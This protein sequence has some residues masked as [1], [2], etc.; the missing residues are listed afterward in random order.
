HSDPSTHR[1]SIYRFIVRSQPDPWMTTMDC[2]DSSQSTPK[3]DETL[4]ALQSLSL[5]NNQFNLVMAE[6]FQER[7]LKE[8]DTLSEQVAWAFKVSMQR[9]SRKENHQVMLEYAR[10]HGLN[11][12]CRFLF[13]FS[14]FIYID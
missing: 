14:E 12:L 4:T 3:R 5:L 11:N 1:R 2:A 9:Q 13:N 8:R 6:K 10:Q 7:L